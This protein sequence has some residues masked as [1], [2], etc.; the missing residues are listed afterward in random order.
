M[1]Y[2]YRYVKNKKVMYVGITNNM[3]RRVRQHAQDK[4]SDLAGATIQ[5]FAVKTRADAELLE[6]Y[7][8]NHYGTGKYYNV[9]KTK[10]G[11]VSFLG[12]LSNLPWVE[13]NGKPNCKMPCFTV[14]D[15]FPKNKTEVKTI[16]MKVVPKGASYDQIIDDFYKQELELERWLDSEEKRSTEIIQGITSVLYGKV[17]AIRKVS[18]ECLYEALVVYTEYLGVIKEIRAEQNKSLFP[19]DGFEVRDFKKLIPKFYAIY[20][21][22][23]KHDK[24]ALAEYEEWCKAQTA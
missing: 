19:I 24:R 6:T 1:Q 2:V 21:K 9:S 23:E 13:Y 14:G 11:E 12:D 10:K 16:E 5:C 15:L 7:L 20:D 22:L 4:L 17:E 3:Q 8:I 18:D